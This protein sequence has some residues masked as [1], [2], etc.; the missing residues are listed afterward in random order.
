MDK[1]ELAQ[2]DVLRFLITKA[3]GRTGVQLAVAIYGEKSRQR[4]ALS[5]DTLLL[6]AK[7]ADVAKEC[8]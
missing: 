1:G 4:I 8:A 3:P 2:I 7:L 6:A 5:L